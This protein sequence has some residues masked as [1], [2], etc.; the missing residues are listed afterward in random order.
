MR[1]ARLELDNLASLEGS[2]VIDF[3]RDLGAAP[4]FVIVGPTGAGKSTL[5][6]A[7]A[8]ALFG[9][10]PR[11]TNARGEGA[12][13]LD[14]RHIMTRGAGRC[15][16][17][18]ELVTRGDGGPVRWR[19][20]W[21]CRRANLAPDGALQRPVRSLE[22]W[23]ARPDDGG[24]PRWQVV[25]D[26]DRR[27]VWEPAFAEALAGLGVAE[28]QR[29]MLLAQGELASLLA[30]S[31][32]DTGQILERLT[33]TE[34]Y[35]V[36]G[37][38]CAERTRD[39]LRE[40]ERLESELGGATPPDEREIA[41]LRAS[42]ATLEAEAMALDQRAAELEARHR[43][44]ADHERLARAEAEAQRDA[45]LLERDRKARS[46]LAELASEARLLDAAERRLAETSAALAEVERAAAP[47]AAEDDGGLA[48]RRERIA[49]LD[50]AIAQA[51]TL[52]A[53][54]ADRERELT[55]LDLRLQ[56]LASAVPAARAAADEAR[57]RDALAAHRGALRDGEPCPLC[58]AREHPFASGDLPTT[59]DATAA[60]ARLERDLRGLEVARRALADAIASDRAEAARASALHETRAAEAEALTLALDAA[61]ARRR[62]R[63]R[64]RLARLD[65]A[66]EAHVHA[67]AERDA[68]TQMHTST[69]ARWGAASVDALRAELLAPTL[70]E[71]L[72]TRAAELAGRR[73]ALGPATPPPEGS[74]PRAL[75]DLQ[76]A[77]AEAWQALGAEKRALAELARRHAAT[78]GLREAWQAA[79]ERADTWR[80][81]HRLIGERDGQAFRDFAQ[82][83]NLEVLVDCANHH[84]RALAPRFRLTTAD[85][86]AGRPRLDFAIRDM[87]QAGR[88][89]PITTLSG[90]ETFLVSLALALG[91][92]DLRTSALP[93]ETL[94]LDEGF[95]TL[96][97]DA[98]DQALT[99]L[100]ELQARTGLQLG[101]ITHVAAV[102]ERIPARIV[103][104]P[105]GPSTQGGLGR[106]RVRVEPA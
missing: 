64:E 79:R 87:A 85:D 2:H 39:A 12:E 26:D 102:S 104:E 47:A 24:E 80:R 1:L 103:V 22:R 76:A 83:M 88:V 78:A 32:A 53:R 62:E 57:V 94:L 9:E 71:R 49:R 14:A 43:L 28:F 16:A 45:P 68:C 13:D 42:V 105:L 54:T 52:G 86:R 18:L 29:S 92:A 17:T 5:L 98:L 27:K 90:G 99:A 74:D 40:L 37:R 35:L 66:R 63:E 36:I 6:D 77:R 95:G 23:V 69:L 25:V 60:L 51:A 101:I 89:R 67:R 8:L 4:M 96:D 72:E 56:A 30:A 65:A 81:L 93:I 38:R 46:A 21:S 59:S 84:L 48:A 61:E 41:A 58:G 70:R 100:E 34:R 7:I 82:I 44:A 11:L 19:A 50:A 75:G 106:S 97:A 55:A 73:A 91:L 20:T 15:R 33:S 3:E 10:T 31:P